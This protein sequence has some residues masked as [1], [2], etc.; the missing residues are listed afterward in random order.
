M[1]RQDD[2]TFKNN[3]LVTE[4]T[5]KARGLRASAAVRKRELPLR[6]SAFCAGQ[7][8]FAVDPAS[9]ALLDLRADRAKLRTLSARR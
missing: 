5:S 8:A 6:N 7:H 9:G 1:N 4:P 2:I 3:R